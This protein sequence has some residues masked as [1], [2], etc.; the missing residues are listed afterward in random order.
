MSSSR[1]L[2]HQE[3]EWIS[4]EQKFTDLI[5]TNQSFTQETEVL[6]NNEYSKIT[7][8]FAT[9]KRMQQQN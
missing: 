3:L 6:D 4:R 8:C 2:D 1:S 7:L 5:T 9:Y